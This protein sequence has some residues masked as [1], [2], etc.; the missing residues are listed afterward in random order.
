MASLKSASVSYVSS[1]H[2]CL[3]Y[4]SGKIWAV[5]SEANTSME[6]GADAILILHIYFTIPGGFVTGS[7]LSVPVVQREDQQLQS[8]IW[9]HVLF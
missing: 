4:N 5:F 8:F 3:V 2:I 6:E 7:D 1:S 9:R